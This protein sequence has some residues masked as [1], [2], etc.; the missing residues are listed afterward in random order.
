MFWISIWMT[1]WM[2][3]RCVLLRS[4][5]SCRLAVCTPDLKCAL[6]LPDG[7]EEQGQMLAEGPPTARPAR[8]RPCS[9]MMPPDPPSRLPA[10]RAHT[11][12]KVRCPLPTPGQPLH[13]P[14]AWE[15][16]GGLA[17]MPVSQAGLAAGP[18]ILLPV[19]SLCVLQGPA[20]A[21][22]PPSPCLQRTYPGLQTP[23]AQPG[24]CVG[25]CMRT[26]AAEA[27]LTGGPKPLAP[28]LSLGHV[29]CCSRHPCLALQ[30]PHT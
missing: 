11:G 29:V 15:P 20:P 2:T 23:V 18:P 13:P 16:R 8:V 3:R 12:P 30:S 21:H 27:G 22:G 19:A 5:A 28:F 7:W 26:Q 10:Y 4:L 17:H 9:K 6:Q 25:G 14:G 1:I 24:V